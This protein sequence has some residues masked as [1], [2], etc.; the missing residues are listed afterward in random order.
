MQTQVSITELKVL[1]RLFFY[2]FCSWMAV[3]LHRGRAVPGK[4]ILVARRRR[5]VLSDLAAHSLE[6]Q[7]N[8][9]CRRGPHRTVRWGLLLNPGIFS[10]P[11][12]PAQDV[13]SPR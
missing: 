9:T 7:D 3:I 6:S 2:Q 8:R 1:E 12:E 11:K 4:P 13:F 5:T 10:A